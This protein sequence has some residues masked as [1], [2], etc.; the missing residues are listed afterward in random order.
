M[1]VQRAQEYLRQSLLDRVR[2]FSCPES[3]EALRRFEAAR[4]VQCALRGMRARK[5]VWRRAAAALTVSAANP[6][7]T[8]PSTLNETMLCDG[9]VPAVAEILRDTNLNL[10]FTP[11]TKVLS[12]VALPPRRGMAP[13]SARTA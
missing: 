9:Q 7:L 13:A 1:H 4:R 12:P 5:H 2:M 6:Y 10:F 11:G 3:A 8:Y